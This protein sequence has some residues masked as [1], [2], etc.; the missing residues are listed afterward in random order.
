MQKFYKWEGIT[1]S[2]RNQVIN[3]LKE[4]ISIAD[5]AIINFTKYS[6]LA[7]SLSVEIGD[8]KVGALH[9]GLEAIM[10]IEKKNAQKPVGGSNSEVIVL[11]NISFAKGTGDLRNKIPDVPG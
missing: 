11:L 7:L 10:K 8:D 9:H 3:E 4:A 2:N 6:D 5:G 1:S